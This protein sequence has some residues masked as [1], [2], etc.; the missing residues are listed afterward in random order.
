MNSAPYPLS[1]K[2]WRDLLILFA[3]ALVVRVITALPQQE[4]G[5][6]DATYY[7][8]NALNLAQGQGFVEDFV[9]DNCSLLAKVSTMGCAQP[10]SL[11]CRFGIS[12]RILIFLAGSCTKPSC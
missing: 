7:Y 4:P 10:S 3:I 5:Y 11:C 12:A 6:F 1:K 8:V 9:C 2:I